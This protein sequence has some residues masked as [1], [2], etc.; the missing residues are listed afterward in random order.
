MVALNL[1]KARQ[2]S[3][4]IDT[5][6]YS[7]KRKHSD[8]VSPRV[9]EIDYFEH[10]NNFLSISNVP[11]AL[12]MRLGQVMRRLP[13]DVRQK[14]GYVLDS[15]I[16]TFDEF[17]IRTLDG[18]FENVSLLPDAETIREFLKFPNVESH[19]FRSWKHQLTKQRSIAVHVRM[20]D[21]LNFPGIYGFITRDYYASALKILGATSKSPIWLF[22]DQPE[23]AFLWLRDIPLNFRII[24]TP[25]SVRAGE[26]MRLMSICDSIVIAHSTFSWWAA[27]LGSLD[28][29]NKTVVMPNRFFSN[30]NAEKF[31]LKVPSWIQ[32]ET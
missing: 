18:S 7:Y 27:Y 32:L 22:S 5:T 20:G 28:D 8:L 24:P 13:R 4:E 26:V 12:H 19:W 31:N 15:D 30:Q 16:N 11:P 14:M 23:Q 25:H 1:A 9:V 17:S 29:G 21:Y 10:L 3:L 6:W 2:A